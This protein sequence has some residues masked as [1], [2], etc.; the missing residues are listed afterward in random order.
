MIDTKWIVA[1]NYAQ[2]SEYI[3]NLTRP[4]LYRYNYV[5]D[6]NVIRGLSEISGL[7]IGTWYNNSDIANIIDQIWI[8]KNRNGKWEFPQDIESILIKNRIWAE[9]KY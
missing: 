7:F 9:K 2:Y 6:S 8:I 3:E 4:H 5:F 1:G